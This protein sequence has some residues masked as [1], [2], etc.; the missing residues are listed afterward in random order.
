[1][2]PIDSK[3]SRNE[4]EYFAR[5]NADRVKALRA[6][7]DEARAEAERKSHIMRCPRC[8]GHLK[9]QTHHNMRIDV[10]A[11][12]GGTW[13]DKGELEILENVE[14]SNVRDFVGSL[15]GLRR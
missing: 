6:K 1:M 13:L 9:E 10:C 7:L 11:E 14:H 5:E 2:S 3:P 15:F 4:D 12:C 8:G